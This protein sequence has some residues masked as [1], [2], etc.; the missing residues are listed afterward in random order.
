[1]DK[2]EGGPI[3]TLLVVGI[4]A[5]AAAFIVNA[6]YDWS[7]ERI[8]VNQRA[9]LVARL[10]SVLDPSL[11][12][13]DLVTT[14]VSATDA[15]LLGSDSAVDVFVVTENGRPVATVFASIAPH[16]YNAAIGLL[17]GVSPEG[18]ITGVRAVTHRET[19][20]LGD[21]IDAA[22]SDWIQQF[23]GTNLALP[24]LE[25][26]AVEQDDGKFDAITGATV[27]SRAV[28]A[29]VKN[30]LLY[31]D[32]HHDELYRAAAAAALTDAAAE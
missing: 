20:G 32:Q 3:K 27:T 26:W 19:R 25:L 13:H 21:A 23:T 29:A 5:A 8:A 28:V 17:V 18:S 22:K 4:V 12:S 6:S 2:A 9:R 10:N 7:H 24:P 30:T 14:R 16:G 15:T 11:R 1:M 31:F